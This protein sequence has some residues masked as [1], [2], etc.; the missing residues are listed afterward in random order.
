MASKRR[1]PLEPSVRRDGTVDGS[2]L[3]SYLAAAFGKP[4]SKA[5]VKRKFATPAKGKPNAAR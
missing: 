3:F 5:A 1:K 4:M 2:A